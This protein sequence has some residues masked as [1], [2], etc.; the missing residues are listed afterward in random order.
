MV[1]SHTLLEVSVAWSCDGRTQAR[2]VPVPLF[3]VSYQLTPRL[4]RRV[5]CILHEADANHT[6]T[7]VIILLMSNYYRNCCAHIISINS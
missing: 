2:S 6:D 7:N 5:G 1:K 3:Q 4:T